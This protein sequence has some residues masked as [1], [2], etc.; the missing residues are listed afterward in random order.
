MQHFQGDKNHQEP[1]KKLDESS[2][3]PIRLESSDFDAGFNHQFD[4]GKAD[5][6]CQQESEKLCELPL[7]A[8]N[9]SKKILVAKKLHCGLG[10]ARKRNHGK[11]RRCRYASEASEME[12][13]P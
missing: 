6:D 5:Y 3:K 8:V 2:L 13:L 12:P 7:V 1:I 11:S 4:D 10:G 9:N